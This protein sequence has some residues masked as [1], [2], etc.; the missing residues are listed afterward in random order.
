MSRKMNDNRY[1][2]PGAAV[3]DVERPRPERPRSVKY[4][5][6]LL[7]L[8]A[9]CMLPATVFELLEPPVNVLPTENILVNVAAIAFNGAIA[10]IF[11]TAT[12][13][14]RNWGRWVVTVMV[15]LGVIGTLFMQLMMSRI[16]PDYLPWYMM[17][18]YFAQNVIGVAAIFFLFHRSANAW[19]AA[20]T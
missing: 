12:W 8:A 17:A 18:Q 16:A 15:A 19:F 6:G 5:V 14:G 10:W 20:T 11:N 3:T 1:A 9:A 7:W 4:G 2:A 13:R